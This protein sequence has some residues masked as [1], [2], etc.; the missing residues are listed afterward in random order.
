VGKEEQ[1]EVVYANRQRLQRP[2]DKRL[3]RKRGALIERTFA[4]CYETGSMRRTHL[5]KHNNILRRRLIHV[6]GMNL[7]LLL[8]TKYGIGMPRGPQGLP[9]ALH[10]LVALIAQAESSTVRG[11]PQ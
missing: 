7:G 1:R 9:L 5:R 6:V 10:F 8:R 4:H 11:M 2:K 3:L